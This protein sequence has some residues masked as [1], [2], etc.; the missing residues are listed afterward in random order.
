QKYKRFSLPLKNHLSLALFDSAKFHD[1]DEDSMQETFPINV[2]RLMNEEQLWGCFYNF[3][4]LYE[5][6]YSPVVKVRNISDIAEVQDGVLTRDLV[7]VCLSYLKRTP[8]LGDYVYIKLDLSSKLLSDIENLK[9]YKYIVYLDLS[10][11]QISELTVLSYLPYV[12]YLDVS[13]NRLCSVL[14][15]ET[16]NLNHLRLL[17]LDLSYNNISDFEFGDNVGLWTLLH[18]QYLNLNENNL[19]LRELHARNNRFCALLDLAV[20][21]SKLRLIT[22]LD[23]RSNPVCSVPGYNDVIVN[24]FPMLLTLDECDL[25]PVDQRLVKMNMSPDA[26][27]FASRR[28]LRLLYIEQ[29]SRARVSPYNPPADTTDVPIVVLV[30]YEAVGKGSLARRLTQELSSHI[31]LAV[32]HTT[33]VYHFPNHY[34]QVSRKEFDDMLLAGQFLTYSEVDGESYGLSRE[35]A[36]VRDAKVR[37]VAMDLIGALMLKLRGRQPYLILTTCLDKQALAKRQQDRKM[38]LYHYCFLFRIDCYVKETTHYTVP[39]YGRITQRN[40]NETI[41]RRSTIPFTIYF[42]QAAIPEDK[43]RSEF[44]IESE[45]SL[46]KGASSEISRK[47]K[48]E[49]KLLS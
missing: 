39:Y 1:L 19:T 18:L 43:S 36:F 25:D 49:N 16:Q 24:S 7:S 29:L 2:T 21:M 10:S 6:E 3:P 20:Y 9:H 11:N 40:K 8:I 34:I 4:Q 44:L 13:F 47:Q 5:D 28:L 23:L 27:T 30:G 46:F 42:Y 14:D 15:Y 26:V 41:M 33:A 12:Q 17:W 32:Q 37:V 22:V 48:N 45:C 38:Y 31:E 35:Q